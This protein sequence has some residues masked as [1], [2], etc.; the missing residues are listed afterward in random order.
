[1]GDRRSHVRRTEL[2]QDADVK[3]GRRSRFLFLLLVISCS[4]QIDRGTND[5]DPGQASHEGA[6][7]YLASESAARRLTRAELD[8]ALFDLLGDETAPASA[9]LPEDPFSPYDNDYTGQ[10]PSGALI[11]SLSWLAEQVAARTMG[12]PAQRTRL[13]PCMPSSARD[14]DCFRQ[15]ARSLMRR[16]FRREIDDA[17]VDPYLALLDF[18]EATAPGLESDFYTAVEL[19]VRAV[20]MDPEF[21]YRIETGSETEGERVSELD[22]YEIATRLSF[23]L[24]GTIPDDVLLDDAKS[25]NL[26]DPARRLEVA[27][28]LLADDRAKRQVRRFHGMWLGYREVPHGPELAAAF[29]RETG[30]LVDRVVFDQP[31]PYTRLFTFE[32]TFIDDFLAE[33]YGLPAPGGE[34]WVKYGDSGRAGLLSHGSFLSAFGKF[35]DT[36]PT[37]RGILIR[38]RLLCQEVPPPPPTVMA[39]M[40]PGD[41]DAVCKE[42]RYAEHRQSA[43]CAG[44]HAQL[45]PIGFGLENYDLAGRYRD[46]DDGLV[47]CA[48]SGKGELP[49]YGSFS[50]PKELADLLIASGELER[51]VVS[52]FLSFA[53]GRP[54]VADEQQEVERLREVMIASD[55]ELLGLIEAFIGSDAFIR[56]K[57]PSP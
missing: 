11:D 29:E 36:S 6:S 8:N 19:L 17:E 30:A 44:C 50:G 41:A 34:S 53:L 20:V 52:Q 14:E 27:S 28:R 31:Q 10:L 43:A 5:Q 15:T 45:D 35:S 46:H 40:P 42:D 3:L 22:D 18:S 21:L 57:E 55:G 25:G 16:A 23:L 48:V 26:A 49:P 54:L 38:T 32:E 13:L 9:A 39:D 47:Q 7:R 1:M 37:Q 2:G 12:D 51:C 56:R 33:H 24:W 4:G